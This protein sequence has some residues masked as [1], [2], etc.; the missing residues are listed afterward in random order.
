MSMSDVSSSSGES[1]PPR[2]RLK[3]L[4]I[5]YT[6]LLGLFVLFLAANATVLAE[7]I[8]E[9]PKY[10]DMPWVEI[11]YG[12]VAQ[13]LVALVAIAILKWVSPGN[14]GLRWPKGKSYV[15]AA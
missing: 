7:K 10:P 11:Y 12:H 8:F 15:G 6:L 2:F 13:L 3:F 14:Y 4:P 5:L 9:L 1:I